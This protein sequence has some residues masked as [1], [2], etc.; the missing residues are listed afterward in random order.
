MLLIVLLLDF[1]VQFMLFV[2]VKFIIENF[3]CVDIFIFYMSALAPAPS[4]PNKI[5]S[6]NNL[7][8]SMFGWKGMEGGR[9][10]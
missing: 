6:K 10:G 7:L 3:A 8:F 1:A 4:P 2:K 9:G 5:Y